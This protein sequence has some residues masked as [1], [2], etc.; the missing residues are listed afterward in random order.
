[1]L[2]IT[3]IKLCVF[4]L[5]VSATPPIFTAAR[6][7]PPEVVERSPESI[8][9]LALN[10][11]FEDKSLKDLQDLVQKRVGIKIAGC[12]KQDASLMKYVRL[13]KK[14]VPV[15]KTKDLHL[16]HLYGIENANLPCIEDTINRFMNGLSLVGKTKFE[17]KIGVNA[18]LDIIKKYIVLR[19]D[20]P[21]V[22]NIAPM[23][24]QELQEKCKIS[25]NHITKFADWS[26]HITLAQI[27]GPADHEG[28]IG[29]K[30][31]HGEIKKT[32]AQLETEANGRGEGATLNINKLQLTETSKT[33]GG[34]VVFIPIMTFEYFEGLGWISEKHKAV[35]TIPAKRITS[36]AAAIPKEEKARS[37]TAL[38]G[39]NH[40]T[41]LTNFIE[42]TGRIFDN[43]YEGA[44]ASLERAIKAARN[45]ATRDK[46]A[47]KAGSSLTASIISGKDLLSAAGLTSA[48]SKIYKQITELINILA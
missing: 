26:P 35:G 33:E 42:A 19:L 2:K 31:V 20:L 5:I 48:E 39:P 32:L 8:K 27:A 18:H 45:I 13:G 36:G 12:I 6:P 23:I 9:S 14:G 47:S 28:I 46:A 37:A 11:I 34:S 44:S 41:V 17:F 21:R 24:E 10:T 25:V 16:S 30:N 22:W 7:V 4:T 29:E 38:W 3:V 40:D 1:M 43:N 15:Y